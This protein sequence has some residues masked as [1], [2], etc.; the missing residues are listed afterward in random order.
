MNSRTVLTSNSLFLGAAI[1]L[2][3]FLKFFAPFSGW[4]H[5]QIDRS[6]LPAAFVP[7]GMASEMSVGLGLLLTIALRA[8]LGAAFKP[9]IVVASCG[10][11]VA[12]AVAVYVHLQ[13]AVPAAVLPLG[14]KPP[15]IPLVFASLAALNVR[16][17]QRTRANLRVG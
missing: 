14:I 4:F 15:I 13:P 6:G 12:M 16:L 7:L 11:V 8:R 5:T 9:A 2:F 1:F 17:A 10:V 3:G